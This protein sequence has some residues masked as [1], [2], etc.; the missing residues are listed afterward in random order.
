[1]NIAHYYFELR[2]R[3][4]R[5][6]WCV[7]D[8]SIGFQ[9]YALMFH[10][11]TDKHVDINESC[12]CT[13]NKFKS[14]LTHRIDEGCEFISISQLEKLLHEKKQGKYCVITFDDVPDNFCTDALPVLEEL[15][16]PFCL[17]ITTGFMTKEGYLSAEQV[18][19]LAN[20]PLCTIGA[21]TVSH[22]KLRY[23]TE[24]YYELTESKKELEDLIDKEVLYMAYPFGRQSTVSNKIIRMTKKAGYKLAF[25]TIPSS[26]NV[27]SSQSRFFLPRVLK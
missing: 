12:Q 22:P 25:S 3:A 17:F 8:S 11:V 26:I 23:S 13:V 4:L 14:I 18:R 6:L 24:P 16:L 10:H 15:R 5:N 20:H 7:F 1:M 21:H 2:C 19:C 27:L 9:C